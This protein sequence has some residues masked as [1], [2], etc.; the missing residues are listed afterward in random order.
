MAEGRVAYMGPSKD[1]FGF[2][3]TYVNNKISNFK[4]Q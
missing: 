1:M 3:E 2:F 4:N